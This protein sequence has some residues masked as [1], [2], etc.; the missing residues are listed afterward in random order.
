MSNAV[1]LIPL[2]DAALQLGIS[3]ER[4]WRLMLS[5]QLTGMKRGNRWFVDR[6]SIDRYLK[7]GA[8]CR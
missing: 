6:R 8:S 2:T 7:E 1:K 5:G 3:W 4:A